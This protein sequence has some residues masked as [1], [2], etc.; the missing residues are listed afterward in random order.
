MGKKPFET[1]LYS[2]KTNKSL[3]EDFIKDL[4]DPNFNISIYQLR[5]L[6]STFEYKTKHRDTIHRKIEFFAKNTIV[7]EAE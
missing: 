3:M 6:V 4:E 5:M 1:L 2:M 7:K